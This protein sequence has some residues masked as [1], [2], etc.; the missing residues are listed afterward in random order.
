MTTNVRFCKDC[1]WR[2]RDWLGY[3]FFGGGTSDVCL[4]PALSENLV[5]GSISPTRCY[6]NRLNYGG[7]G[8]DAK[9]FEPK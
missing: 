4:C 3:L 7:C 6:I 8:K 9:Y 5:T 2:R 1:R